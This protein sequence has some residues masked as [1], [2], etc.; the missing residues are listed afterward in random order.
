MNTKETIREELRQLRSVCGENRVSLSSHTD[1]A[2]GKLSDYY[3]NI[4]KNLSKL[5]NY[6]ETREENK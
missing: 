2:R 6:L 4:G 1:V 5:E 3:H